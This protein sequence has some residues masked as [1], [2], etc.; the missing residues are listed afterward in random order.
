MVL[1]CN[2]NNPTEHPPAARARSAPS[3]SACRR[4]VLVILDEAYIEFQTV[5]DPD[6]SLDLLR[7]FENLVI[8]RTFSKVYGLAGLRVGY[9]LGSEEFRA[10]VD[11]VRQ[12]FSV[13]KLAQAAATEALRHQDNVA[14]RV[15]LERRRAPVDGGGAARARASTWPTA[16]RTSAGSSLGEH[17]E[18]DGGRRRSRAP[19]SRCGPGG[20]LG[21]A[22]PPARDLRHPR[23]ERALHRGACGTR[24]PETP[25]RSW[26][27]PAWRWRVGDRPVRGP[28]PVRRR[29]TRSRPPATA[30]STCAT[31]RSTRWR[32]P[33][34]TTRCPPPTSRA[35][36]SRSRSRGYRRSSR[37]ASAG[38]L[39][40][41]YYGIQTSRGVQNIPIAKVDGARSAG[42][43]RAATSTSATRSARSGRPARPTRCATCATSSPTHPARGDPDQHRG[44]RAP[45]GRRAAS[46][47]TSGLDRYVWRGPLGPGAS[48][49]CA[50]MIDKD[51]AGGRDGRE[52]DRRRRAVAA[53]PV[54]PGPGDALPVRAPPP[55]WPR[56]SSC[57][58]NRGSARNPLFLLNNWVDTSPLPQAAQRRRGQRA[59]PPCCA[60]PARCQRAA[61]TGSRTWWRSTSTSR[62]T[63]WASSRPST[64]ERSLD[65]MAFGA[66]PATWYK[67]RLWSR[68]S[69]QPPHPAWPSRPRGGLLPFIPGD[70]ARRST[71][72]APAHP[73]I[74]GRAPYRQR[75]P[76]RRG[77]SR[78]DRT[79]GKPARTPRSLREGTRR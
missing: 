23:R 60:A 66:F 49:R 8:L 3:S 1:V 25:G 30:A 24:S 70:L 46:S 43:R 54:R 64:G 69:R 31:A 2:P 29:G 42:S 37:P 14:E 35:G 22:G 36:G 45:A 76:S 39:I 61:R 21:G 56:E 33:R 5:E 17:D 11:R 15:E 73:E 72:C 28:R 41:M 4:S 6:T 63:C 48:R 20:A 67:G 34:P 71:A 32:S 58:P 55:R 13:N 38:L 12:P 18:R 59:T 51:R 44:L 40:D 16:R 74:P 50:E 77:A 52:P 10:A 78:D 68:R 9:A 62:A 26:W 75:N 53:R 65:G 7:D 79:P 19:A 57:R 47:R 27:Q